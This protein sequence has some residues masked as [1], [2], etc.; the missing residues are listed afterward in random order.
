MTQTRGRRRKPDTFKVNRKVFSVLLATATFGIAG[1]SFAAQIALNTVEKGSGVVETPICLNSAKVDFSYAVA[2]NGDTTI[3]KVAVTGID[4]G[5]SGNY[6]SLKITNSSGSTLDEIIWHPTL[7]TGDTG[8][9]LRA[10]GST[11]SISDSTAGG[12]STSWPSSQASPEGLQSIA[13][14]SVQT[15]ILSLLK[16]SRAAT[17]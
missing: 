17:N 15:A 2:D 3:S 13:A 14:T 5:C 11:T 4:A 9:T 6:I 8:I 10:D 7:S 16:A 12:I 1:A